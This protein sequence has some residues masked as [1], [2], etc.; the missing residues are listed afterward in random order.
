MKKYITVY[1]HG[2]YSI[3]EVNWNFV[4]D[5]NRLYAYSDIDDAMDELDMLNNI[6]YNYEK[7]LD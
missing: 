5:A 1:S 3:E 7:Y 4:E 2:E 6:K